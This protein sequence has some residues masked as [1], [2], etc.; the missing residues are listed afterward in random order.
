MNEVTTYRV[1]DPTHTVMLRNIFSREIK[2]RFNIVAESIKTYTFKVTTNSEIETNQDPTAEFIEWLQKVVDEEVL[3]K[4][5]WEEIITIISTLWFSRYLFEAYQ[6]GVSRA[7]AEMIKAGY[8]VPTIE[9]SGGIEIVMANPAHLARLENLYTRFFNDL[10]AITDD[11]RKLISRVIS[12]GY[13]SG[14]SPALITRKILAV[15][16]GEGIVELGLIET[17]GGR[18]VSM[19]L[20]AEMLARTEIIRLH[21]LATIQEY[22]LWEI[23]GVVIKAEIVTAGDEKVCEIC[24]AL[25]KGGPYTLDEAE[26]M[27]PAHAFCRC[28]ALPSFI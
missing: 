12:D 10:K 1:Y 18:F 26:K 11:M 4:K 28:C 21:H 5:S 22:R 25:E 23:L 8:K 19:R 14:N 17:V 20:R 27:I 24:L 13:L 15:I 7:R 3:G 9:E 2:R 6:R 16:T